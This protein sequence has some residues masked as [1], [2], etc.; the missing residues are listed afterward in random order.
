MLGF[1]LLVA[2]VDSWEIDLG[3]DVIDHGTGD[4]QSGTLFDSLESGGGV[5][6]HDLRSVGGFEHIDAGDLEAQD[7]SG[8]N[9]GLAIGFVQNDGFGFSASVDIA[10]EFV[11]LGDTADRPD[12]SIANDHRPDVAAF[13]FGDELLDQHV[14]ACELKGFDD[15]F[16]DLHGVGQDDADALGSL[17]QLDNNGGTT[18]SL[19]CWQDIAPGMNKGRFRN[20]D[21]VTTEDLQ[22]AQFVAGIGDSVRRISAEN[23]HLFELADDCRSVVGDG[24]TDSGEDGIEWPDRLT[25]VAEIGAGLFEIDREF[26]SIENLDVM[27]TGDGCFAQSA[28]AVAVAAR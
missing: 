10:A 7:L 27:S 3:C 1:G 2:K 25:P 23:A 12:D 6:L 22:A 28:G 15:G 18:N 13:A 4:I 20:T 9:R 14:L 16:G 19:D 5:D 8:L 24:R 26:Q 17:D 21:I 11:T